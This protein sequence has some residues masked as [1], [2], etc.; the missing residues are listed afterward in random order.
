MS[1]VDP[2]SRELSA[3]TDATAAL[4]HTNSLATF[5]D[6]GY[7]DELLAKYTEEHP[8]VTVEQV[9]AAKSEDARNN[10]MSGFDLSELQAQAI[11][12]LRLH[13]LTGLEQDKI[14]QE[15]KE[16]LDSI[17]G[18]FS[19]IAFGLLLGFLIVAFEIANGV[20]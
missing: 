18:A 2:L 13:R 4:G 11:L 16:I 3:V 17:G 9:K 5:N 8:N 10:L 15:F 1:I 20:V 6:F 19:N 7:S 14:L 12:D